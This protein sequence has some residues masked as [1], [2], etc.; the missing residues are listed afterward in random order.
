MASFLQENRSQNTFIH[1][2]RETV[3]KKIQLNVCE[4]ELNID[5]IRKNKI[6]TS[7]QVSMWKTISRWIKKQ[8]KKGNSCNTEIVS[9]QLG[10]T[11]IYFSSPDTYSTTNN[12]K[13]NQFQIVQVD[14]KQGFKLFMNEVVMQQLRPL[15]WHRLEELV[16]NTAEQNWFSQ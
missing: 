5:I 13:R 3:C 14:S 10:H 16:W 7:V 6:K 11:V 2:K 12:R 8:K 9:L 4:K 1:S 15:I